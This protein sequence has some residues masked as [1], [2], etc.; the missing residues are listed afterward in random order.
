MYPEL[1]PHKAST[2]VSQLD[3]SDYDYFFTTPDSPFV[4]VPDYHPS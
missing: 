4:K 3:F 2:L 1:P